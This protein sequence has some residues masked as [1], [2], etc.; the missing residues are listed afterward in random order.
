MKRGL[1]R[2]G[3]LVLAN[4]VAFIMTFGSAASA[5]TLTIDA[6]LNEARPKSVDLEVRSPKVACSQACVRVRD[7]MNRQYKLWNGSLATRGGWCCGGT[8]GTPRQQ[9]E[10]VS[11]AI[12]AELK[13][14][15]N[16]GLPS[17][18]YKWEQVNSQTGNV[19]FR[20][21][22]GTANLYFIYHMQAS[23]RS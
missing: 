2:V 23:D 17:T 11:A 1:F 4:L 18:A 16:V 7:D 15:V 21:Y 13:A 10:N 3:I 20:R 19:A 14:N 9:D 12:V 8:P 22:R 5:S 6:N